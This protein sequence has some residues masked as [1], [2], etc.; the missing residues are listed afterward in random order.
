[1]IDKSKTKT[2]EALLAIDTVPHRSNLRWRSIQ[3]KEKKLSYLNFNEIP[4][5][6]VGEILNLIIIINENQSSPLPVR[7]VLRCVVQGRR[8]FL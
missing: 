8:G 5:S 3:K 2:R 4:V 6:I 1:M 7:T